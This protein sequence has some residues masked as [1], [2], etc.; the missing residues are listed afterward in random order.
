MTKTN[1]I[2]IL[3]SKGVAHRVSSYE[4][5][6]DELDAVSIARKIGVA[7]ERVFKTL[8]AIGDRTGHVVFV[9]PG[10]CELDLKKAA[11]ASGDKRVEMIKLKDLFPTTGYVRGGCSPIGM[12]KPFPTFIDETAQLFDAIHVSAG[13]RGMQVALAPVDLVAAV[14]GVLTDLI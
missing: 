11:R 1:A 12:K 6:E 5:S 9:I 14:N 8:V 4:W 7:P 3:E 13:A 10:D 2:R